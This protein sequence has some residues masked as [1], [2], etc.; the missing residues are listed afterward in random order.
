MFSSDSAESRR[1]PLVQL[2]SPAP[3]PPHSW[4][5]GGGAS[6]CFNPALSPGVGAQ[7]ENAAS[8]GSGC[9]PTAGLLLPGCSSS[10]DYGTF[11]FRATFW[12]GN[13]FF[14][15]HP[16]LRVIF[17]LSSLIF[18]ACGASERVGLISISQQL[19][20]ISG[21]TGPAPPPHAQPKLGTD[22]SIWLASFAR[23]HGML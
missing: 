23:I 17:D 20:F 4:S 18:A 11:S 7:R 12:P 9:H 1:L 21:R 5:E 15:F 10:A 8:E 22:F 6:L 3:F 2:R 19:R 14:C 13:T 16:P